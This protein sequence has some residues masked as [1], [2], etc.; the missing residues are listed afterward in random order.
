MFPWTRSKFGWV[1]GSGSK[2][3]V[4]VRFSWN[5]LQCSLPLSD[6]HLTIWHKS[7]VLGPDRQ[8][9]F[10]CHISP[11]GGG[12]AL[13]TEM[14]RRSLSLQPGWSTESVQHHRRLSFKN[15]AHHLKITLIKATC[16]VI[17]L[18]KTMVVPSAACLRW[19]WPCHQFA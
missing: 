15:Q 11:Q 6:A 7:E 4:A 18:L 9:C 12:C 14:W 13:H 19:T 16:L 3:R 17:L 5:V 2:H 8:G 10:H 1:F